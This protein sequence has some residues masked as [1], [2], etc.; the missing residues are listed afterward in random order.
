MAEHGLS[1][2]AI[3]TTEYGA[4][5]NATTR[6]FKRY[7]EI[8]MG[9]HIVD[10]EARSIDSSDNNQDLIEQYRKGLLVMIAIQGSVDAQGFNIDRG[11][12]VI[13]Q[14]RN[15]IGKEIPIYVLDDNL[16]GEES[17][18]LG[19]NIFGVNLSSKAFKDRLLQYRNESPQALNQLKRQ[20]APQIEA[21]LEA[22]KINFPDL[23]V[24]DDLRLIWAVLRW[25]RAIVHPEFIV[26][27]FDANI[28][29]AEPIAKVSDEQY[30]SDVET[31]KIMTQEKRDR[32]RDEFN[33][34][35]NG[36]AR[37]SKCRGFAMDSDTLASEISSGYGSH[38]MAAACLLSSL[39]GLR[40]IRKGIRNESTLENSTEAEEADAK[41]IDSGIIEGI[42]IPLGDALITPLVKLINY[43]KN[44]RFSELAGIVAHQL[45]DKRLF[46]PVDEEMNLIDIGNIN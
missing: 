15:T 42:I 22:H 7:A 33:S 11:N 8:D 30:L 43:E 3:L 18:D 32:L 2:G 12:H 6:T 45:I 5:E 23:D 13:E 27:E 14:V 25:D 39:I 1:I 36:Q 40:H 28:P 34:I 35:E 46:I 10:I 26:E 38:R 41:E 20:S 17:L 37:N 16:E 24:N 19:D 21:L 9:Y 4:N 44:P 29:K 31:V